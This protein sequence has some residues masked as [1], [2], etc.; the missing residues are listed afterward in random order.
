[1]YWKTFINSKG[2]PVRHLKLAFGKRGYN[3][4]YSH[5]YTS[6]FLQ[7]DW[8]SYAHTF[9]DIACHWLMLEQS[10]HSP[11]FRTEF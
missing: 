3:F 1:M 9:V 5:G 4:G 11:L 8:L 2:A 6:T 7:R 10:D